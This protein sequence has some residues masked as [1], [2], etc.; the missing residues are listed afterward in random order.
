M[1]ILFENHIVNQP[2]KF[3]AVGDGLEL[4]ALAGLTMGYCYKCELKSIDPKVRRGT[5][6]SRQRIPLNGDDV[7]LRKIANRTSEKAIKNQAGSSIP[8][9]VT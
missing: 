1:E 9:Q 5:N 2:F 4:V 8:K 6:W 3:A 7:I